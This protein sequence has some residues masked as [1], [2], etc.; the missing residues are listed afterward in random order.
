MSAASTRRRSA[1]R[2][3]L[4]VDDD[5]LIRWTLRDALRADCRVRLAATTRRALDI[6]SSRATIDGLLT[7]LHLQ[8]MSGAHL[9]RL[10][11]TLR[12]GIR[13]FLM[14]ANDRE[15]GAREAFDARADGFLP[16]PIDLDTLRS[17]LASHLGG[18]R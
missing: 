9:A 13:V 8:D 18:R 2:I 6:L 3:L 1:R 16:K 17:M 14:T 10:A 11:R 7:D 5:K 4:V 12:P 15:T